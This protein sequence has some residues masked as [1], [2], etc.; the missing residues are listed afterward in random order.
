MRQD[1]IDALNT[2]EKKNRLEENDKSFI[3]DFLAFI[4]ELGFSTSGLC[5]GQI[6]NW[7]DFIRFNQR[8]TE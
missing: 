2:L 6:D 4:E 1:Y 3:E 5:R 8:R 7:I